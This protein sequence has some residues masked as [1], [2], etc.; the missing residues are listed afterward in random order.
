MIEVS[1]IR[2]KCCMLSVIR[3]PLSVDMGGV[4][5]GCLLLLG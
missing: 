2:I 1:N 5:T 3:E 4:Y